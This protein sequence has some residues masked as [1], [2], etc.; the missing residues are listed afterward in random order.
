[1]CMCGKSRAVREIVVTSY[2]KV[3]FIRLNKIIIFLFF[4]LVLVL[5]NVFNLFNSLTNIMSE[6]H[7][8]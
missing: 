5:K 8:S 2:L 3:K 7:A 6:T 1:M 4:C